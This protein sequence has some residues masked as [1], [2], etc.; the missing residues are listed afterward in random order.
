MWFIWFRV[1][2]PNLK[3]QKKSVIICLRGAVWCRMR[4]FSSV[5]HLSV[6]WHPP[7]PSLPLTTIFPSLTEGACGDRMSLVV[8]I[9]SRDVCLMSG[10]LLTMYFSQCCLGYFLAYEWPRSE[11]I[12][13]FS[14]YTWMLK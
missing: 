2:T 10:V 13:Q 14:N 6:V 8:S 12:I 5:R 11:V 9:S 1:N 3:D 4:V 7:M